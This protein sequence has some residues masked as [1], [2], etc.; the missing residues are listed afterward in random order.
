VKGNLF[1]HCI[2][3]SHFPNSWK[4]QKTI[5]FQKPGKDLN[6]RL[7]SLLSTTGKFKKRYSEDIPK[8]NERKNLLNS[9]QFGFR[10]NHGT[11]LLCMRL[12]DHI[13]LN[14]NKNISPAAV[15][16]DIGKAFDT[17]WHLGLLFKLS[18]IEF[19][20]NLLKFINSFLSQRKLRISVESEMSTP[21]VIKAGVPQG[22][23]L[24]PIL[25]NL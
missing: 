4:E 19:S 23:I 10:A 11:T 18:T 22:S 8:A 3:R 9:N 16:L 2:Q 17:L 14:F 12:T 24:C 5:A 21:R 6:L 20:T 7:I 25:C 13:T 15:F 1:S